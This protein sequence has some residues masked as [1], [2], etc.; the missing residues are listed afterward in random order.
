[1]ALLT[2]RGTPILYQGDELLMQQVE[3]PF[4][5]VLDPVGRRFWPEQ[6]GR[7]GSRTPIPWEPGRGHG[8]TRPDVEPWLPFGEHEGR[9]VA[10]QRDDPGSALHLARDLLAL[11]RGEADL[12]EG[13]Y[14]RLEAPTG[15]WAYRRGDGIGVVLNLGDEPAAAPLAGTT[16]L[17][18]D[19][20]GEGARFDG[21]L[22][23]GRG[24]VLSL[25]G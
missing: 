8:F 18:T 4:E 15:I 11:R 21:D 22:G 2:Q 17:A 12:R 6:K 3:V 1:V 20:H 13:A 25:D 9:T 14:E 5:R 7:D 16:L 19:R 23:P 24:V 10:D